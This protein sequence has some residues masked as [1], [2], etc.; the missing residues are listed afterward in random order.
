VVA[1]ED[2]FLSEPARFVQRVVATGLDRPAQG[3]KLESAL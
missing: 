3:V 2:G 1:F